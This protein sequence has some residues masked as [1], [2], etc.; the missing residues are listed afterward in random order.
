[1]YAFNRKKHSPFPDFFIGLPPTI[2]SASV[3]VMWI[4]AALAAMYQAVIEKKGEYVEVP[5]N[6]NGD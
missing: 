5:E 4:K 3:L 6:P 2:L 1:M